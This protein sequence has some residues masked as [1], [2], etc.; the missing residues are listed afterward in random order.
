MA[1]PARIHPDDN[2]VN[3]RDRRALEKLIVPDS[4][5][6]I[7]GH[8]EHKSR[9]YTFPKGVYEFRFLDGLNTDLFG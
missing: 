1:S 4:G 2:A 9:I 7:C 3:Q 6:V 5:L 8:D